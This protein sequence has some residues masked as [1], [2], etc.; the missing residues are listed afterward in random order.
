MKEKQIIGRELKLQDAIQKHQEIILNTPRNPSRLFTP[1]TAS[2]ANQLTT[3]QLDQMEYNRMHGGAHSARIPL[4]GYDMKYAGK[5]IP[6]WS[7]VAR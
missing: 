2:R 3:E 1:T 5:A 4:G 7:R 6:E